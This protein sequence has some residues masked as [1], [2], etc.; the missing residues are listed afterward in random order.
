MSDLAPLV[1]LRGICKSFPPVVANDE[2][3]FELRAG[4]IHALLGENG[5]GKSSLLSILAGLYRPD[6]GEVHLAGGAC[7]LTSPRQARRLGIGMVH[8]HFL[9]ADRLTVL[10]NLLRGVPDLPLLVRKSRLVR[11]IDEVAQRHGL[12]VP[13]AEP[14]G[15]LPVGERQKVE[16]LRVLLQEARV[17]VL[18]EPTAVLSRPETESL[19]AMLR[20]FAAGGGGVIFISHKLDEVLE[21]A[22]RVTVLRRG[23]N[24]GT[25]P[26]AGL[27]AAELA[28]RMVGHGVPPVRRE[29]PG[30]QPAAEEVVRLEEVTVRGPRG[31]TQLAGLNLSLRAGELLGIAGVAGSGQRALAELLAGLVLPHAGRL[32]LAGQVQSRWSPRRAWAAGVALVP[33]DRRGQGLAPSLTVAEN[34]ILTE[35]DRFTR[36][37]ILCRTRIREHAQERIAGEQIAC[38]GPTARAGTLSGGNLQKLI[39]ARELERPPRLLIAA[40]P[41]RGLDLQAAERV[42]AALL[43][44]ARQGAAVL[45]ISED[46]DEL[47]RLADRIG[48]LYAG[49]LLACRPTA[50]L[51]REGLGLLLGGRE[52]PS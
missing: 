23:R 30:E 10:D 21:L 28:R 29:P 18:D 9:Q 37:G 20:S 43:R 26:G 25:F 3:D 5:A 1:S 35:R 44:T 50:T 45:L 51:S 42:R 6:A 39:L 47:L 46:L 52:G 11:R 16:L 14:V 40:Y 31:E 15:T 17:L 13:L 33:E 12:Q 8:Q 41:C 34:L 4:E 48:V 32:L 36:W 27:A 49:R 2:V 38:R 24:A 22:D 7:R 19:F